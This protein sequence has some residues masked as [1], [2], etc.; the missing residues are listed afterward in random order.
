MWINAIMDDLLFAISK[1]NNSRWFSLLSILD[2]RWIIHL[3]INWCQCMAKVYKLI[4]CH[5]SRIAIVRSPIRDLP[6]RVLHRKVPVSQQW[7]ARSCFASLYSGSKSR[8]RGCAYIA[9][10]AIKR[11]CL[12]DSSG[13]YRWWIMDRSGERVSA[14]PQILFQ[15][16]I[17]ARMFSRGPTMR[18]P[19]LND[20]RAA[21]MAT[22]SA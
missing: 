3:S 20:A 5:S 13:I 16:I 18:A 2:C 4:Y 14:I 8:G 17:R 6:R 22:A 7:I 1:C 21:A 11:D 12:E 15:R 9:A 10:I 19:R